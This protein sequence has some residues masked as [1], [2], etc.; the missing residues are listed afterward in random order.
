MVLVVLVADPVVVVA[1]VVVELPGEGAVVVAELPPGEGVVV[2]AELP[3]GA[4][5]EVEVV[6]VGEAG[7][8]VPVVLDALTA[9]GFAEEDG[10]SFEGEP[11]VLAVPVDEVPAGAI[12][13]AAG[14]DPGW[15]SPVSGS[16]T[17]DP[18]G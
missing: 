8:P 3:P 11:G 1:V 16:A 13:L 15:L 10:A 14:G 17:L 6:P 7:T 9:A 5:A 2:V 12:G 4:E 18:S